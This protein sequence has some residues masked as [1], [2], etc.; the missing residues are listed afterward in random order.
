MDNQ[1]KN[2]DEGSFEKESLGS[3]ALGIASNGLGTRPI[4]GSDS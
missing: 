4:A 2:F 1:P 3:G